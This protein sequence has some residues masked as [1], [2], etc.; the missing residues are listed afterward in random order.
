MNFQPHPQEE[1]LK[2]VVTA[3]SV[4]SSSQ[5][6]KSLCNLFNTYVFVFQAVQKRKKCRAAGVRSR[7]RLT[8]PGP[9]AVEAA[10]LGI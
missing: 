8:P 4:L 7:Q 10:E 5:K 9:E 1:R 3:T 2:D 6:F